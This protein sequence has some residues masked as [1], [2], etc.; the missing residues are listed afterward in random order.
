LS[1]IDMNQDAVAGVGQGRVQRLSFVP[2]VAVGG[3]DMNGE[4]SPGQLLCVAHHLCQL[5]PLE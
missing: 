4:A 5:V 1:R 3:T 2:R